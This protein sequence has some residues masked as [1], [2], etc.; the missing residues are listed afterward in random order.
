MVLAQTL[1]PQG[2]SLVLVNIGEDR[3]TVERS[4]RERGYEALVV[5]DERGEALRAF[6]VQATPTVVLLGRQGTLLGRAIGPRAWTEPPGRAL[7]ET[8]LASQAPG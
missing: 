5:L 3:Q 4:V 2:L 1:R 8:L 7:L 6:S